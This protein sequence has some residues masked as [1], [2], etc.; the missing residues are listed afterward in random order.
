M[1]WAMHFHA[2]FVNGPLGGINF[3]ADSPNPKYAALS[4]LIYASSDSFQE[5]V[6]IRWDAD[7]INHAREQGVVDLLPLLA[8]YVVLKCSC[9]QE[10]I[11]AHFYHI[12]AVG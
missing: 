5:G 11:C 12:P 1:D 4:K 3:S 2:K 10:N 6:R 8:D 9:D 7:A